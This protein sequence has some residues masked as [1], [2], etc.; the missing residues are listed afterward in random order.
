MP[1]VPVT[2]H[3]TQPVGLA[4]PRGG[5]QYVADRDRP[6]ST[7]AG[8]AYGV[9]AERDEVVVPG[10]DLQPIGLLG[11]GGIVVQGGDRGL[12][13][14]AAETARA[15]SA[16]CSTRTPSAISRGVPEAAVLPVERDDAALASSRAAGG[17]G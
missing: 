17:R 13:L 1:A 7:A 8:L 3:V 6:P 2:D 12:D 15:A 9:L 16:D 5:A 10:E 11:A 14:V 4:Q